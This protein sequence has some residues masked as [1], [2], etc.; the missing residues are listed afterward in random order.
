MVEIEGHEAL[1]RRLAELVERH[2]AIEVC[3]GGDNRF[4]KVEQTVATG[5]LVSVVPAA[6]PEMMPAT[7]AAVTAAS[8]AFALFSGSGKFHRVVRTAPDLGRDHFLVMGGLVGIDL[9]V[10]IEVEHGEEPFGVLGE[11]GDRQI[12]VMVG[13]GLVEPVGERVVAAVAGPERLAHRADE[14]AARVPDEGR[15]RDLGCHRGSGLGS[16]RG[17]QDQWSDG[18][19]KRILPRR[20]VALVS[21]G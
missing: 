14:E 16:S 11:L 5:T 3:V 7:A 21:L 19:S 2:A 13:I 9:A 20:T 10:M 1:H 17:E 15:C 8:A 6:C 4:G 18:H 12:A